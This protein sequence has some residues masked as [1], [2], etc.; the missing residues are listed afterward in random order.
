MYNLTKHD[1]GT[2]GIKPTNSRK[3]QS[4]VVKTAGRYEL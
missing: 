3:N 4:E 1:L 2:Q